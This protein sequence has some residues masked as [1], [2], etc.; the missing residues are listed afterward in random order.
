MKKQAA[1][2][3]NKNYMQNEKETSCEMKETQMQ[4]KEQK[5]EKLKKK[6]LKTI[7]E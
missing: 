6:C 7:Q 3:T 5:R 2:E 4:T 1:E